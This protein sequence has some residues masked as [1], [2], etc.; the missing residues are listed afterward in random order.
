M[1]CKVGQE[2]AVARLEHAQER[3]ILRS[4]NGIVA[5]HHQL[6]RDRFTTGV[7][8]Y[9]EFPERCRD[10]ACRFRKERCEAQCGVLGLGSASESPQETAQGGPW[11]GSQPGLVAAARRYYRHFVTL[12]ER[13][14]ISQSNAMGAFTRTAGLSERIRAK[15]AVDGVRLLDWDLGLNA[16]RFESAQLERLYPGVDVIAHRGDPDADATFVGKV[17]AVEGSTVVIK[18]RGVGLCEELPR[19]DWIVEAFGTRIGF[20]EAHRALYGFIE[21]RSGAR[22]R[23]ILFGTEDASVAD[24]TDAAVDEQSALN[25]DQRAAVRLAL[26]ETRPVLVH[27]PPGTGKTTVIAAT[28][29]ALVERGDRVLVAAGTNTAVDNVLEQLAQCE[30]DFLRLGYL[31]SSSSLRSCSGRFDPRLQVEAELGRSETSLDRIAERLGSVSVVAGTTHKCVS[32]PA[33]EVIRRAHGDRPFDVAIVDEATQ[34]TEPMTLGAITRAGR[35]VLVGDERQL[36]P[37]VSAEQAISAHVVEELD[38]TAR[39]MGLKGL[40]YTL[41]ERLSGKVPETSLR[42][43]Y[44]MSRGVQELSNLLYYQNQL[45]PHDS[46][47][48]RLLEIDLADL[49]DA[50]ETI[51]VRLDPNRPIVWETLRGT[52]SSER[53]NEREVDEVVTTIRYLLEAA[54]GLEGDIGVISPFRAQCYA[55]RAALHAQLGDDVGGRVEVDTVERF[56]GR[57]KEVMFVSLV[58]ATWSDF[59][60]DDRRLNVAFTRARSKLIAFGPAQLWHRFN[61]SRR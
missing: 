21:S 58:V 50:P 3:R 36:P 4:R 11:E 10:G 16:L 5:A 33:M 30:V 8:H 15:T 60:M 43:Q 42:V 28:V 55:I 35:F 24:E 23:P 41:F 19:D 40:D 59:V 2:K 51:R 34:I 7:P 12:I 45:R 46:V 38:T 56:Q 31:S 39:S 57:E 22:L 32:S 48:E 9:D 17:A 61:V 49:S 25:E 47:A 27:G 26:A 44:R 53:M 18:A 54:P 6:A 52:A 13:E 37:V 14:Y 20:R 29:K 1:Y